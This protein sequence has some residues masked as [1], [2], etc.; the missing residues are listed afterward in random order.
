[1]N[2]AAVGKAIKGVKFSTGGP[3]GTSG[4]FKVG[5]QSVNLGFSEADTVDQLRFKTSAAGLAAMTAAWALR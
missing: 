3:Y 1:M 5:K 2:P 4:R